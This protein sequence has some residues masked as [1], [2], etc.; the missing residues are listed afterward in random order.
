MFTCASKSPQSPCLHEFN[1]RPPAENIVTLLFP[2]G[3]HRG[4]VVSSDGSSLT[5]VYEDGDSE[6]MT[7]SQVAKLLPRSLNARASEFL[8][9]EFSKSAAK[10]ANTAGGGGSVGKKD[11]DRDSKHAH[12][13]VHH[14][15]KWKGGAE[16]RVNRSVF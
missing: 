1:Y 14:G 15:Q 5:V 13:N 11:K 8:K 4:Q 3:L 6:T 9:G 12:I 16:Q 2:A 10:A 7:L